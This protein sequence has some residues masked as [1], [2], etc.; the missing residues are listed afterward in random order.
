MSNLQSKEEIEA[1][2]SKQ[3]DPWGYKTNADD[4]Q[5]RRIII[6]AAM[7]FCSSPT[8]SYERALDIGA[9]EGFITSHL[10]AK[11]IYGYELSETARARFPR[12]VKDAYPRP[13]GKFDLVVATGVLYSHYAWKHFVELIKE[14]ASGLLI[15]SNIKDWE[16]QDAVKAL[17]GKQVYNHEYPYREY[18]QK[19]R[20]FNI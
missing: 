20:V 4:L 6:D 17:P 13:Y 12:N 3:E 10:P 7:A 8:E 18:I 11:T 1:W 9:G 5:R 2:Y 15:L 16:V 14:H 19:L